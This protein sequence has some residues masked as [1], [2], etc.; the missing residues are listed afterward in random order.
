MTPNEELDRLLPPEGSN[1]R[2]GKGKAAI[3]LVFGL[4]LA[5]SAICLALSLRGNTSNSLAMQGQQLARTLDDIECAEDELEADFGS[6]QLTKVVIPSGKGSGEKPC[7]AG[8]ANSNGKVMYKCTSSGKWNIVNTCFNCMG[9][10]DI[11]KVAGKKRM[12]ALRPAINGAVQREKCIFEDGTTFSRG[13]IVY[14]CEHNQWTH[15]VL[16]S[17]QRCV[18]GVLAV[19]FFGGMGE[20]LYQ[21]AEGDG[22]LSLEC[23]SGAAN[24]H[25][26]VHVQCGSAAEGDTGEWVFASQTCQDCNPSAIN[27]TFEEH[28]KTLMLDGG[29]LNSYH[30]SPCAFDDGKRY[31]K[32][33]IVYQCTGDGW[34]FVQASCN[35]WDCPAQNVKLRVQY[36]D[37]GEAVVGQLHMQIDGA[38]V[39]NDYKYPCPAGTASS[40]GQLTFACSPDLGWRLTKAE[41]G[42]GVQEMAT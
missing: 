32:G 9:R 10:T 6:G 25:G 7:P 20:V 8:S 5:V 26:K 28:P 42:N 4:V 40:S 19:N 17:N 37:Q 13:H 39:G 31:K 22:K 38:N 2:Q 12:V 11:A 33:K 3:L 41:C 36:Q 18:A 29:S 21:V 30:P 24:P 35:D 23:P 27:I 15:K 14:T 1:T 34:K 16:C